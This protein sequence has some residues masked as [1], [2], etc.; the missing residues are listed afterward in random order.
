MVDQ[1]HLLGRDDVV[2][3]VAQP[4]HRA[5]GPGHVVGE[6][7]AGWPRCRRPPSPPPGGQAADRGRVHPAQVAA[8]QLASLGADGDRGRQR[9]P[10]RRRPLGHRHHR[11]RRRP[12]ADRTGAARRRRAPGSGR[13]AGRQ[14]PARPAARP[15]GR[16]WAAPAGGAASRCSSSPAP[17]R[18]ASTSARSAATAAPPTLAW[19][20]RRTP[21][22]VPW[23]RTRPATEA[24]RWELPASDAASRSRSA[25]RPGPAAAPASWS[26]VLRVLTDQRE[27]RFPGLRAVITVPSGQRPMS[28]GRPDGCSIACVACWDRAAR[29]VRA[30]SRS[31]STTNHEGMVPRSPGRTIGRPFCDRRRKGAA[32]QQCAV[33]TGHR[34]P[35]RRNSEHFVTTELQGLVPPQRVARPRATKTGDLREGAGLCQRRTLIGTHRHTSNLPRSPLH[36]VRSRRRSRTTCCHEVLAYPIAYRGNV[37]AD[38]RVSRWGKSLVGQEM[39]GGDSAELRRRIQFEALQL[40]GHRTGPCGQPIVACG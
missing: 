29:T 12:P 21:V 17:S 9:L 37:H 34:P 25:D 13:S 24:T 3:D 4:G 15:A 5:D 31:G 10:Q 1:R 26:V 22:T 27:R 19:N 2:L 7:I 30:D 23:T 20:T 33:A 16:G 32:E 38:P 11:L 14:P 35:P 28:Q 8:D 40:R 36:H 39:K 18:P 6:G